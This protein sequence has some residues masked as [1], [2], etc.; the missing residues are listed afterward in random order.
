MVEADF[1]NA[2]LT[3]VVFSTANGASLNFA[4]ASL[5]NPIFTVGS[6]NLSIYFES[7]T[8]TN[9]SFASG[10]TNL[11]FNE[12]TKIFGGMYLGDQ[13]AY[14]YFM[15]TYFSG[16]NISGNFTTAELANNGGGIVFYNVSFNG[17]NFTGL[18]GLGGAQ[19]TGVSWF[20]ATCP[21]G[22]QVTTQ[23]GTCVGH[24]DP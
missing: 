2:N 19:F 1:T 11:G 14:S 18:A 9:A 23:G 20:G 12:S 21:D 13:V 7:S 5:E 10:I 6:E 17:A 16:G 3:N 24:F 15:E 22:Y 8:V 4:Y